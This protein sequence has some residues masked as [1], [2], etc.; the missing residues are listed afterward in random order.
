MD[1]ESCRVQRV[2]ETGDHDGYHD[3]QGR[4]RRALT[5]HASALVLGRA[6]EGGATVLISGTGMAMH[7]FIPLCLRMPEADFKIVTPVPGYHG[8]F[9]NSCEQALSVRTGAAGIANGRLVDAAAMRELYARQ[10]VWSEE[11]GVW[12]RVSGLH[13]GAELQRM[14]VSVCDKESEDE[15]REVALHFDFFSA[16]AERIVRQSRRECA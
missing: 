12:S 16:H 2:A 9:R 10:V 14:L 6:A 7:R 13:K 8:F 1:L 11:D 3:E 15:I 5:A 4:V